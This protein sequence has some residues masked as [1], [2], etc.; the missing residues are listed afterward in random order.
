MGSCKA[1]GTTA[2]NG[3][4][5]RQLRLNTSRVDVD[6]RLGLRPI[7]L[8]QKTFEGSNGNGAIDFA[9]PARG[10]TGMCADAAT[11]A[12]QRVGITCKAIGF[13]KAT[14]GNQSYVAPGV[15]VCRACH[16]AGEIG[17]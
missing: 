14:L 4:L 9:A 10:F 8:R 12:G 13:C 11:N 7:A 1:Y 5:V 6:V 17:V 16:H 2:Y 15:R 3:N